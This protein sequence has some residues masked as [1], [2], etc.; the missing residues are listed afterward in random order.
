[1]YISSCKRLSLNGNGK[2]WKIIWPTVESVCADFKLLSTSAFLSMEIKWQWMITRERGEGS[3]HR[4][5]VQ[6]EVSSPLMFKKIGG[7]VRRL[8]HCQMLFE[9]LAELL[10]FSTTL[11]PWKLHLKALNCLFGESLYDWHSCNYSQF[12]WQPCHI[13]TTSPSLLH[14]QSFS[15]TQTNFLAWHHSTSHPLPDRVKIY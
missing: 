10:N 9:I 8:C 13:V 12:E 2:L 14:L 4:K 15:Q 6:L 7:C 1:M 11:R 5:I 3:K